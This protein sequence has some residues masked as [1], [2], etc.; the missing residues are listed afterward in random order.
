MGFG[1]SDVWRRCK[2]CGSLQRLL[3]QRGQCL[4]KSQATGEKFSRVKRRQCY[5]A[6]NG[7]VFKPSV[8][9]LLEPFKLRSG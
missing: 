7:Y 1:W 5:I 9:S 4:Q 6:V 2:C 8:H 3:L